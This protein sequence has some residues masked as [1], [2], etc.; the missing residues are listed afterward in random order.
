MLSD[1]QKR[2]E[3]ALAG[4]E[5]LHGWHQQAAE[6][7]QHPQAVEDIPYGKIYC[8]MCFWMFLFIG[9]SASI[10]VIGGYS[11]SVAIILLICWVGFIICLPAILGLK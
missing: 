10:G 3:Y 7:E 6:A 2:R 1:P 9:I 5:I 4:V 8:F 11:P